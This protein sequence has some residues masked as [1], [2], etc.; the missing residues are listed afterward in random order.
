[1]L[2]LTNFQPFFT[3]VCDAKKGGGERKPLFGNQE[4]WRSISSRAKAEQSI[5]I[6]NNASRMI[7]TLAKVR[8]F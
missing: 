4:E 7:Q 1:M 2:I 3:F 5:N 6:T 8:H